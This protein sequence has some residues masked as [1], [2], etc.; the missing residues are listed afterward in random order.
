MTDETLQPESFRDPFR[1][2]ERSQKARYPGSELNP[3]MMFAEHRLLHAAHRTAAKLKWPCSGLT[4]QHATESTSSTIWRC[5]HIGCPTCWYCRRCE[6]FGQL[7]KTEAAFFYVKVI[8]SRWDRPLD[9]QMLKSFRD[10]RTGMQLLGHM[11][12][13]DV[14]DDG[15][16][17]EPGRTTPMPV[18]RL[19]GVF[20][21]NKRI[22]PRRSTASAD[23]TRFSV[24]F[25]SD[26]TR[27]ANS[28]IE[29]REYESAAEVIEDWVTFDP[30]PFKIAE[31]DEYPEFLTSVNLQFSRSGRINAK[32][33]KKCVK[34]TQSDHEA[35]QTD[36]SVSE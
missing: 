3:Q 28:P 31:V 19:V 25:P 33:I 8:E 6:L 5:K 13:C 14:D 16:E 21:A 2:W 20:A 23:P 11:V 12:A 4:F 18:Y 32:Q 29:Y 1:I 24:D 36:E 7:E 27:Y 30:Y 35:D 10:D 15:C 17:W 9:P 26:P 22:R 34:T